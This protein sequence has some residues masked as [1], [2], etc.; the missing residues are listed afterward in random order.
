MGRQAPESER[1]IAR[2]CQSER[3]TEGERP[4]VSLFGICRIM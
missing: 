4:V 3:K 1:E 2:E